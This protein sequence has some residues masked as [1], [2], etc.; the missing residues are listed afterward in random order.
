MREETPTFQYNDKLLYFKED[1]YFASLTQRR[2][3]NMALFICLPLLK[4]VSILKG[5]IA[6]SKEVRK[7]KKK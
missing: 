6:C 3:L 1:F 4:A 7:L 5:M 2:G